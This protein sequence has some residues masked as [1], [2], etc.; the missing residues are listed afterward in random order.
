MKRFIILLAMLQL[1]LLS[2]A[3]TPEK[4]WGYA[5][6]PMS[7]D[8]YKT[9]ASLW[10]K[11]TEKYPGNEDA[12][13]NL[14]KATRL[15]NKFDQ[16]NSLSDEEK[17]QRLRQL[18]D[19]MKKAIPASYTYP[20]CEWVLGGNDMNYYH[21][22]QQAIA[23]DPERTE[24]IDYMIN[25][26][27][28]TR[29][30]NQRNQYSLKKWEVHDV[31]PGMMY[32]N[33]NTLIGLEKNAL[34][35]TA[36]DNDTYPAWVLQA[37]GIRPDITVINLYLLRIKEYR[38]KLFRELDLKL[39]DL[40]GDK[41]KSFFESDILRYLFENKK[42]YPV[43]LSLTA[44]GCFQDLSAIEHNLYLTGLAYQYDTASVDN[45]ALLRKNME[46]RYQL[47]YLTHSFYEEIAE[48]QVRSISINYLIPMLKLYEHYH[49]SGDLLRKEWIR[50]KLILLSKG[51]EQEK[52]IKQ[53]V[54]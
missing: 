4:I 13:M 34:L 47:D 14:F 37:R 22:L 52:T 50:E 33:Y 16:E 31:S 17:Q 41:E 23:L 19:Q 43:Y 8:Y 44:T 1:S 21:F 30:I 15:L 49:L 46:Q 5:R 11:E 3:Q 29:D 48:E 2:Q 45:I 9:Q 40:S 38:E 32:Y 36:G 51:T 27:E 35:L 18:V 6:K 28:M 42:Q 25:I 12:W 10:T 53:Y 26:G 7:M 39:P 54:D 24:H 20:Y